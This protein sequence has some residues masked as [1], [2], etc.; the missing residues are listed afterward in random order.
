MPAY[1]YTTLTCEKNIL[2]IIPARGGK[3]KTHARRIII[4]FQPNNPSSIG[5]RETAIND[6][7]VIKATMVPI[8]APERKS[9]ATMGKLIYGPPGEKPPATVPIKIPAGKTPPI[10]VEYTFSPVRGI[11]L[12]GRPYNFK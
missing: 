1:T 2:A 8:L 3:K 12:N 11:V 7:A 4:T 10:P 5:N 9:P 6:Q